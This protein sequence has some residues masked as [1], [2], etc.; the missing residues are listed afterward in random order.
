MERRWMNNFVCNMKLPQQHP[1][2][3]V[4]PV[5]DYVWNQDAYQVSIRQLYHD[6]REVTVMGRLI[7]RDE[8]V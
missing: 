8:V 1:Y 6:R 5:E 4:K 7:P 3:P 2:A